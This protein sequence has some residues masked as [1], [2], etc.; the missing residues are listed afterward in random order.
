MAQHHSVSGLSG[1]LDLE[2]HPQQGD[3]TGPLH[4]PWT[5]NK[6]AEWA[7]HAISPLSPTQVWAWQFLYNL[8][9]NVPHD[10]AIP[11]YVSAQEKWK[12][13]YTETNTQISTAASCTRM[14]TQKQPKCLSP[15]EKRNKRWCI[16]TMQNYSAIKPYKQLI[17]GTIHINTTYCFVL[18]TGNVQKRQIC[19]QSRSVVAW[20]KVEAKINFKQAWG[21]LEML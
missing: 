20:G 7:C 14:E 17:Y 1:E 21:I 3:W 16:H 2:L 18:F 5:S 4:V 9:I 12:H 8:N 6:E 19:I 10:Q 15:R 13:V 11:S